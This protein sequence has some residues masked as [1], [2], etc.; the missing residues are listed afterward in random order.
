MKKKQEKETNKVWYKKISNW[1]FIVICL[2]LIPILVANI[3]IMIQSKT[4]PNKVPSVFGYKPFIVLSKSMET[5]IHKG[6]LIFTKNIDPSTLKKEDIIAFRD[7]AGTV[8]THRIMDIVESDGET[9]FITK[10][11]NNT[12][13]DKNLVSFSDVEGLMVGKIPGFGSLMDG[14]SK[15][16]TI[17]IILLGITLAF[18]IAFMIS[19]KRQ[20]LIDQKEYLEFKKMKEEAENAEKASSNKMSTSKKSAKK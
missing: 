1:F 19:F 17:I 10:G 9:Y 3:Y 7:E 8:T 16:T 5:K 4:N 14:L 12:S 13:Q 15:P 11:D 18:V 2:I 20:H 6:D